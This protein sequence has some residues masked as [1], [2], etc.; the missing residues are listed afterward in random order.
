MLIPDR[1]VSRAEPHDW[2]DLLLTGQC[3]YLEK[4]MMLHSVLFVATHH[5]AGGKELLKFMWT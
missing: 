5:G 4:R 2:V 3:Q 1:L